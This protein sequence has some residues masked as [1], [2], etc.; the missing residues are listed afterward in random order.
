MAIEIRELAEGEN[1]RA[2][3]FYNR[4]Y[5]SN[6]SIE[7]F[8][9][10]FLN[11]PAGKAVYVIALDTEMDNKIVGAHCVI[12]LYMVDNKGNT[13]LTAKSEEVIVDPEYRKNNTF[14]KIEKLLFDK[15]HELKINY[16]W[17]FSYEELH[18]KLLKFDMPYRAVQ[19]LLVL[20]PA[21]AY[22][23]LSALNAGNKATD[24]IKIAGLSLLSAASGLKRLLASKVLAGYEFSSERN[25]DKTKL[26]NNSVGKEHTAYFL[27]Q[28][29]AYLQ[30]R[31][32][33]NPCG[34]TYSEY[35]IYKEGALVGDLIVNIRKAEGIAY[36]EQMLF[37]EKIDSAALL[38][39]IV[40][41]IAEI[42]KHPVSLIRYW[43]FRTNDQN[44]RQIELLE[45]A[46]FYFLN[47]GIL[48]VWK[49]LKTAPE[50]VNHTHIV[51]SRMYTQG[52]A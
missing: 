3:E 52:N 35:Q 2:N 48:F 49:H 41:C 15:V 29:A 38:Q 13:I 4:M 28:D 9:W 36:I 45:K 20:K 26:F 46:G 31:L 23:F 17:G 44:K 42:Q 6:R 10:E 8:N 16:L 30:W 25:V 11:G 18:H 24:K 37:D 27:R 21:K 39:F 32:Y 22:T 40:H 50:K 7:E 14:L 51:L 33:D 19:G 1:T 43:G 47:R 12:P 5:Q 34:N